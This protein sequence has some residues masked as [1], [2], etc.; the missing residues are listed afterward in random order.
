VT[1]PLIVVNKPGG[2]QAIATNYLSQNAG[3]AHELMLASVPLLTNKLAGKG[4]LTYTDV[5]PITQLFNEYVAFAVKKDS[6]LTTGKDFVAR[7][8]QDPRSLSVAIG[9]ALGN[10]PHLALSLALKEAGVAIRNVR[11]VVFAGG[12][13]ATMSVLGG[14]VDVLATTTGNVAPLVKAG[15]MR[16]IAVSSPKRLRDVYAQVPTWKEQGIDSEFSSFRAM[17]G[18]KG[19]DAAQVSY[20]ERIFARLAESPAWL[21][22]IEKN[23]WQVAV[24][25]SKESENYLRREYARLQTVMTELGL[26]K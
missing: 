13:E 19:L 18:P 1:V 20:W 15:Q 21:Q 3:D 2:G 25:G 8:K 11:A 12:S 22:E 10:G 16:V 26:A 14:H 24:Q 9:S 4:A 6:P 5:T 17:V 7:L 23:H